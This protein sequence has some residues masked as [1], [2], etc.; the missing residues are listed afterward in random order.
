MTD[1]EKWISAYEMVLGGKRQYEVAKIM[2]V[3]TPTIAVWMR[4]AKYALDR[5]ERAKNPKIILD[6]ELP[7]R[8]RS[9]LHVNGFGKLT[10]AQFFAQ[11][12][13]PQW[14]I[15]N[16]PNF[17]RRSILQLIEVLQEFD[18]E[19]TDK[20]VEKDV[21]FSLEN[22]SHMMR[23]PASVAK[24]NKMLQKIDH[25]EAR[26]ERLKE[27][28]SKH[29]RAEQKAWSTRV[30]KEQRKSLAIALGERTG[31][32]IHWTQVMQ[33]NEYVYY[34]NWEYPDDVELYEKPLAAVAEPWDDIPYE[35]SIFVK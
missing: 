19:R 30:E 33:D 5:K 21:T 25:L 6:L 10:F 32:D 7:T 18:K 20:W 34:H 31:Q 13:S 22:R 3:A 24:V 28:S 11:V 29:F 12:K 9:C 17:G 14:L 8:V 15:N 16:M 4:R 27:A 1:E 2:G 35:K 23:P 26:L